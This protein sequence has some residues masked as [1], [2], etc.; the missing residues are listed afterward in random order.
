MELAKIDRVRY[1]ELTHRYL[2]TDEGGGMRLLK[3]VTTL[4]REHGLSPD[5]SGID[6]AVLR[7]AAERG[8]EIHHLLEDY[9][10]GRAVAETPELKAYRRLGL[11][12]AASEYLV[13]DCRTVA[14]SID[15]VIRVD[16]NTVDLGDVK[17]TSTLHK[18][19]VAW[20][21]S[22]YK[23]LFGLANPGVAVRKLYGIHVRGGRAR[24]VE[25]AEVPPERVAALFE[26][27]AAGRRLETRADITAALTPAETEALV[28]TS[29]RIE[30]VKGALKELEAARAEAAEKLAAYMEAN[31]IPELTACGC[32]IRLKPGYNTERVDC[33]R[34]RD[35]SPEVYAR[36]AKTSMV[37]ASIIIKNV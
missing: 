15:K 36:Y 17:T 5:Y 35:E 24:L 2:L 32:I 16:D 13:S 21:L 9:D 19:A 6:P 27:E 7:R 10:N 25:V 20:Q 29:L 14:S 4:M 37:K 11:A 30:S 26:A 28:A 1:D 18:D 8:T 3:G 34:L 12:V 31:R 23:W 22:I 33:R